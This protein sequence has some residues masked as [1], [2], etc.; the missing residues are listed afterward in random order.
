M[1]KL[2]A[3]GLI[4]LSCTT[5]K[6]NAQLHFTDFGDYRRS[7]IFNVP[8]WKSIEIIGGVPCENG[9]PIDTN[10]YANV[11]PRK[12]YRHCIHQ[13]Y[14]VSE[15]TDNTGDGPE[16]LPQPIGKTLKTTAYGVNVNRQFVGN[17]LGKTAPPDNTMAVSDNGYI[18]SADNYTVDFYATCPDTLLRLNDHR[19]FYNDTTLS[20]FDPRVI[21]DRQN[22]RFVLIMLNGDSSHSNEILISFSKTEDPRGGWNH[23]KIQGDTAHLGKPYWCD[24]PHLAQNK[25]E[26]F[27]TGN[28]FDNSNIFHTN[29]I[30]QIAKKEG[31]LGTPLQTR[32][33]ADLLQADADTASSIVPLSHADLDPNYNTGIYFSNTSSDAGTKVY[34]YYLNGNLTSTGATISK[35]QIATTT[36]NAVPHVSQ[37][38]GDNL[39]GFDCR[40]QHGFYM[41]GKLYTV[42]FRSNSGWGQIIYNRIK[43]SNNT[44]T[45][46]NWGNIAG[47]QNYCFPNI[48]HIGTD[49][50]DENVIIGFLRSGPSIYPEM[51]AVNHDGTAF[52]TSSTLIKSSLGQLDYNPISG[53]E[54]RWG[55]YTTIQ[56]KYN[57]NPPTCWMVGQ[58]SCGATPNDWHKSYQHNAYIAELGNAFSAD[59]CIIAPFLSVNKINKNLEGVKVYPNPANKS[60]TI[61]WINNQ[62]NI[63]KVALVNL[64]GQTIFEKNNLQNK[65]QLNI[66]LSNLSNGI[67]FIRLTNQL[68]QS[69][70][71]KII[72]AH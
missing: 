66:D 35:N 37:M 12:S 38:G 7:D 62:Y 50:T 29:I 22:N 25:D 55:D 41:N 23:Y 19:A 1:K 43:I 40:T 30:L 4:L 33:F 32:I 58:Y 20:P 10:G 57:A 42:Y 27:I 64:V 68:N 71:E 56:R 14:I 53:V 51:C 60:A 67:Y 24:Y 16:E 47:S 61:E 49:T 31:Y 21:Y 70:N 39:D 18:V 69:Y 3:A 13:E 9:V 34:W 59:T 17:H 2:I 54:E 63:S 15:N 11:G 48:A 8:I 6:A 65:N 46:A 52:S 5:Q 72:V 36:Y 28:I 26:I 45:R 44:L